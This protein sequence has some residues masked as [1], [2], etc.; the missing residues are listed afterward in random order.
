MIN[1]TNIKQLRYLKLLAIL[2]LSVFWTVKLNRNHVFAQN[3]IV[4]DDTLGNDKSRVV[5]FEGNNA[6]DTIRG[7]AIRGSNLFHSFQEFNVSEDGSVYFANPE[8]ITDI[9]SRV[10]GDNPSNIFGKLGVLGDANL[11][12]IN[13]N[14]IVFGENASLDVGGSFV[15]T[16]AN[17]IQ[18]GEQGLFSASNPEVPR[19]LNVSPSA[20]FFNAVE[21]QGKITNF[22]RVSGLNGETNI[23]GGPIGLQVPNG[24]TLA[25]IGGNVL[26]DDGNLTAKGGRVEVGSIETG[27]VELNQIENGL[28]FDYDAVNHFGEVKL[29]NTAVVDVTAGNGGDIA[30]NGKNI[31]VDSSIITT[32]IAEG[33][34]S[35]NSQA[36]NIN[37]NASEQITIDNSDIDNAV[38]QN[39]VGNTGDL[40]IDT[41]NL[42]LNDSNISIT[43]RGQGKAGNLI[44]NASESINLTRESLSSEEELGEPG[45]LLNQVERGGEGEG[46]N[47]IVE[48]PRLSVSNGSKVQVANFGIGNPGE[49]RINSSQI[50]VFNTPDSDNQFSTGIFAAILLDPRNQSLATGQET[51]LTINTDKLSVRGGGK[52]SAETDGI[53]NG[54]NID[55]VARGSIFLDG[56]GSRISSLVNQGAIGDGGNIKITAN[57]LSLTNGAA[58]ITSTFG[59]GKAG[60]IAIELGDR[61]SIDGSG[62][63]LFAVTQYQFVVPEVS[64]DAG[65]SLSTAQDLTNQN[66]QLVNGIT[67]SLASNNDVDLYQ[68]YL[69]GNQTFS[70]TTFDTSIS[71]I[72]TRLFLF[73]A[74]GRGVYFNDDENDQTR[75]STLPAGHPLTPQAAGNYYLAITSYENEPLSEDGTIFGSGSFTDILGA[76]G[77]G[78]SQPL[79]SWN[80]NG[81][82][83]GTYF[84]SITDSSTIPVAISGGTGGN[85]NI[86]AASLSITNGAQISAES[87]G[88]GSA[89]NI[90]INVEGALNANN[91]NILTTAEQASGGA[92]NITARNIRLFGDSDIATNVFSGAGGGGDIIL[93]ANTIIALDDSDILSFAG[94]GKGGDITFNTEAFFSKPLYRPTATNSN[95]NTLTELD[96]NNRVDV[97]ASGTV[98]GT[99]AGIPDTT[100]IQDSLTELPENQIDT[101]TIIANS[102]IV[103]SNEQNGTF[104]ITGAGGLPQNPS[105]APLSSYSTGSIRSIPSNSDKSPASTTNRKWKIG[106]PVVEPQGVYKLPNG[107]LVLSRECG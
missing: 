39:A 79:S 57:S 99:I 41:K 69:A 30:V 46:G 36:G 58:I 8:G 74:N 28:M 42:S 47:L 53:G 98:S 15:A 56:Q 85:I 66:G 11:F 95:A 62:S 89:G 80:N 67:G 90:N 17:A 24:E 86:R 5:P 37:L 84:I 25:L 35:I 12:L 31:I 77:N 45:G 73:D 76:T 7:G 43:V 52:I 94:D 105:D 19:L 54:G 103:R 59:N 10:T 21:N 64:P 68:I 6:I 70:A 61:L 55:I 14:G 9:F 3:N 91:G 96:N 92:I 49:L 71:N 102:C 27:K 104:L 100:F 20:L 44:V 33:S 26:L 51:N 29:E 48:T 78:G 93:N 63:G 32:G 72:D 13:P 60:N 65:Q 88:Q 34:G 107:Q 82:D 101:N 83:S 50:D 2:S 81:T 18:F 87:R 1:K 38:L 22:S 16:T 40:I 75:Q 97:N 23:T 106:D 4:P